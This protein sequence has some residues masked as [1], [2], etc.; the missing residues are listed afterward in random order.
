MRKKVTYLC[1]DAKIR[2][3]EVSIDPLELLHECPA[4][5]LDTSLTPDSPREGTS[6]D[7]TIDTEYVTNV[8]YV[9]KEAD[10]NN[11]V[12][13]GNVGSG[14]MH[15]PV[16]VYKDLYCDALAVNQFNVQVPTHI[17]IAVDCGKKAKV[18]GKCQ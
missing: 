16:T 15:I 18:G 6:V 14:E 7:Y 1:K 12:K 11:V 10:T 3:A 9:C 5:S 17:E 13:Q 8:S 4:P 2:Q